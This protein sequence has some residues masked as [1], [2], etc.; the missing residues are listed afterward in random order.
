MD[1]K[2]AVSRLEKSPVFRNWKSSNKQAFLSSAFIML[3]NSDNP[4]WMIDY[5]NSKKDK[6]TSFLVSKTIKKN[7]DSE[8]FKSGQ[9][10]KG[11]NLN[12]VKMEF[13]KV[14]ELGSDFCRKNFPNETTKKTIAVLQNLELG[15]VWNV[16]YITLAY[17]TINLK[18]SSSTGDILKHGL[19]SLYDFIPRNNS[20]D[21]NQ[22]KPDEN[23]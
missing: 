14:L 13:N 15:Q 16:T 22:Q 6:I 21:G 7:P 4:E 10:I 12:E 23:F 9:D 19:I 11:V 3:E 5:Y 1:I 2:K 17:K 18:I 20:M 8:I